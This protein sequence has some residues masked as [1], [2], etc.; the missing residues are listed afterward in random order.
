MHD[1]VVGE[2]EWEKSESVVKVKVPCHRAASPPSL[3][4]SYED[5]AVRNPVYLTPVCNAFC[6]ECAGAFDGFRIWLR[7]SAHARELDHRESIARV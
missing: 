4:L 1:N 3:L 6:N 7:A 5:T 2:M